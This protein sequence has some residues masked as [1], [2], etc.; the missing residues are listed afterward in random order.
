MSKR[1]AAILGVVIACAY[2][3]TALAQTGNEIRE[4]RYLPLVIQPEMTAT[5]T[6]TR[7]KKPPRPT[8]TPAKYTPEKTPDG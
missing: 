5:P 3:I 6:V 2:A 4:T 1:V 7:T 8:R